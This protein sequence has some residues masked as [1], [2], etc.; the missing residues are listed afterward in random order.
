MQTTLEISALDIS[1]WS[2]TIEAK[3]KFPELIRRLITAS[4]AYLLQID[5]P[6]G[7]NIYEGGWDG[8]VTDAI[9][10]EF[11]P[12]GQSVWELG[13]N[14]DKR[15]KAENDYRERT[16]NPLGITPKEAVFVLA[17]LRN[18]SASRKR[19]WIAEK[20]AESIWKDIRLLDAKDLEVWLTTAPAV[21]YWFSHLLGKRPGN[22]TDIESYWLDWSTATTPPL[23]PTLLTLGR[24]SIVEKIHT[25]LKE[26]E[27]S[28]GLRA[29]S[30]A[31]ALAVFAAAIQELSENDR[32]ATLARCLV[33]LS[34]E[35]WREVVTRFSSLLLIP[36]FDDHTVISSAL[37]QGHQVF[38]P[39]D[40]ADVNWKHNALELPR[41]PRLE[42]EEL[43]R[44]L[45]FAH[46][47]ASILAGIARRSFAAFRRALI[48]YPVV[49]VPVW[50]HTE[51]QE[52]LVA[53][54]LVGAWDEQQVLDGQVVAQVAGQSYQ[55]VKSHLVRWRKEPDPPVRL[56]GSTWFIVDKG[57]VWS[58]LADRITQE[59]LDRFQEAVLT[60]LSSVPPRYDLPANEHYRAAMLGKASPYSGAL[61]EN[62]ATTLAYMGSL[63]DPLPVASTLTSD[64]AARLVR[65]LLQAANAD[66]RIWSALSRNLRWLA[67]AAPDVFLEAVRLGLEG[68]QPVILTLFQER[69]DLLTS[70]S[71][72][73]G[74]LWALELLA[75]SP[76]YLARA[77]QLLAKLAR[78]DPGGALANRPIQSLREIFLSWHP[79]TAATLEQRLQVLDDLQRY[80][81]DIT[82]RLLALLGAK[83]RSISTGTA[84]PRWR[85]W[86]PARNVSHREVYDFNLAIQTRLL[87]EAKQD[88]T[89][90]ESIIDEFPKLSDEH[91]ELV[92]TQLDALSQ[93]VAAD[94]DRVRLRDKLREL[95]S[96]HRSFQEADWALPLP[97]ITRLAALMDQFEPVDIHEKYAWLFSDWPSLP[98]GKERDTKIYA[99]HVGKRQRETLTLLFNQGGTALIRSFV[100]Q[101]KS[102]LT[103]GR[104][105]VQANLLA[106]TQLLELITYYLRAENEA[107]A[108]FGLGLASALTG[109]RPENEQFTWVVSVLEA[110]KTT[111]SPLQQ[112][113]WLRVL[114]VNPQTWQVVS[115]LTPEAQDYYWNIIPYFFVEKEDIEQAARLFLQHKQVAKAAELLGRQAYEDRPI[116][117]ELATEALEQLL[118]EGP[119]D[120]M[121]P[122]YVIEPLLEA[123]SRASD[124]D[125][126]RVIRLEFRFMSA[127]FDY[128]EGNGPRLI[129]Q[130]LDSNPTLFT[131]LV[132]RVF[133]AEGEEPRELT[134]EDSNLTMATWTLLESWRIIPGTQKD[135]SIN[136]LHLVGWVEQ[137]R[138]VLQQNGRQRVGDSQIGQLLSSSP[139]GTDG[140][141]PHEAVRV[142]IEQ[143]ASVDM[144]QGFAVGHYNSRGVVTKSIFEG[145]VQENALAN[146]YFGYATA[147]EVAAP[148]TAEI[149]RR[150]AQN[151]ER[152][153]KEAD[154]EAS[155]KQDLY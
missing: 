122:S 63:E 51:Q 112:A 148:R 137:V 27:N 78:L 28:L 66:W 135:G 119:A 100:Q 25:W 5:F 74:L 37:R 71:D 61:R 12:E 19:D 95:V 103:L 53:A 108:Y 26:K 101:V 153:A 36:L 107:D 89:R 41:L 110:H 23:P 109:Q 150:I 3:N 129:Y 138:Q 75:W 126:Q 29:D 149:L 125:R 80:E 50:V 87:R 90:W 88:I 145:G 91:Q 79:H 134:T 77:T 30:R 52:S 46:D 143:A 68:G 40:N 54:L 144:E 31:E 49:E 111:W 7:N 132:T 82:G 84:T 118:L 83:G 114:N 56:V 76:R 73:P 11:I 64:L 120:K 136:Q 10:T 116:P 92:L 130:E 106:E 43:L 60:V 32:L 93:Q 140:I 155:L 6:S 24:Q 123:L 113:E 48:T 4:A 86:V 44:N 131:D 65:D 141:W 124:A 2:D 21:Q 117:T 98:E 81:P 58:L 55:Q 39:L 35:A 9:G 59:Q 105:L 16:Q 13:T 67:E 115:M 142:V 154:N 42:V 99:A 70:N 20:K 69:T 127:S 128:Q 14:K 57:D 94:A 34:T 47:K 62:L 96:R 1:N 97:L 146:E 152:Q 133:R 85:D 104:T 17:T 151:Y 121:P 22:V 72:H 8:I 18:W 15:G 38:V 45:Y 33:V 139:K 102:P 147:L